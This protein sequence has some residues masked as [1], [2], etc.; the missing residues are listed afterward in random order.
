MRAQAATCGPVRIRWGRVPRD[1]AADVSLLDALG[2]QQR[3]RYAL[4]EGTRAQRF[5]LG[6]SLLV[7][8]LRAGHGID[9][10]LDTRCDHCGAADHGRPRAASGAVVSVS[11]SGHYVAVA[12]ASSAIVRTVGIDIE[13]GDDAVRLDRLAALFAPRDPPTVGEWTAIEAVLKADGR[14]VRIAPDR[15]HVTSRPG[16]VLPGS[17]TVVLPGR[18][19]PIEVAPSTGPE[20]FALSVAVAP[21]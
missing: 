20:G 16:A 9:I 13:R 11:Y 5:L 8:L 4:L 14:G 17:R 7:D 3:A 19:T 21:V 6:R 12:C 10:R 1:L 15:V 18:T 2:P